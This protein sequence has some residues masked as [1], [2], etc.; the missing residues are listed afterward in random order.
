MSKIPFSS[1]LSAGCAIAV[2]DQAILDIQA[3]LACQEGLFVCLEGAATLAAAKQLLES[4]WIQAE[5]KVVRLNI[6]SGLKYPDT[7]TVTAPVLQSG[8]EIN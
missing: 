3:Q 1:P 6:G 2:T 7:V 5:E 4:G 8:D